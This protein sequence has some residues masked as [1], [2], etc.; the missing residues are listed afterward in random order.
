MLPEEVWYLPLLQQH[1]CVVGMRCYSAYAN[2]RWH[3]GCSGVCDLLSGVCSKSVWISYGSHVICV[4][5]AQKTLMHKAAEVAPTVYVQETWIRH[6]KS[7][8]T[9]KYKN[10]WQSKELWVPTDCFVTNL[11]ITD[12]VLG[13]VWMQDPAVLE[14]TIF[15]LSFGEDS[16]CYINAKPLTRHLVD[17]PNK[18]Q[19][20]QHFLQG[21]LNFCW[22]ISS[23]CRSTHC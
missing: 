12:P 8:I 5:S 6:L 4:N 18:T 1:H 20:S 21:T 13:S 17:L 19:N 14:H 9:K 23:G 16:S 10:G 22:Q 11:E 7:S 15:H 3:A 2:T